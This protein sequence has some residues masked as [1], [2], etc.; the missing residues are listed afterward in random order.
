MKANEI[1]GKI[2]DTIDNGFPGK[3]I[4]GYAMIVPRETTTMP[5]IR[6]VTEKLGTKSKILKISDCYAISLLGA[7][8]DHIEYFV[9]YVLAEEGISDAYGVFFC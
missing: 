9:N 4:M 7:T 2:V 3:G 8:Y 1:F 6:E 5:S